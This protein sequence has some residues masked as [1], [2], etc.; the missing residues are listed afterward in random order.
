[1]R[2]VKD[3][4]G[5]RGP[6]PFKGP[7]VLLSCLA[8][9]GCGGGDPAPEGPPAPRSLAPAERAALERQVEQLVRLRPARLGYRLRW[10]PARAGTRALIDTARREIRLFPRAGDPAHLVA[11]DLAHELGHAFDHERLDDRDRRAY[12]R[13]RG[14]PGTTWFPRR[15]AD[16]YR[17]GAEDFA[18]VFALCHAASPEFRSRVAPQPQSACAVLPEAAASGLAGTASAGG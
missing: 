16:P 14:R 5:L 7:L 8:L 15:G 6:A 17:F 4:A 13:R 10:G 9:S 2:P 3:G 1:V 11:H 18:E 12:L